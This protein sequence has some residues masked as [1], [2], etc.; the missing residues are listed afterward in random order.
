MFSIPLRIH[1]WGG[2][3]SQLFALALALD[4]HSRNPNR[5]LCIVFHSAG[6]TRRNLE[7]RNVPNFLQ[8][9]TVNDFRQTTKPPTTNRNSRS[10][11]LRLV[12]QFLKFTYFGLE[13]GNNSQ[14]N[15]IKPW[16]HSIRG[17]YSSRVISRYS[18][19]KIMEIIFGTKVTGDLELP[20]RNTA[21][22]HY[23]LG[24][25]LEL[26][27]KTYIAPN[28]VRDI[29]LKVQ[30]VNNVQQLDI[31]SDS[32]DKAL[33]FLAILQNIVELKVVAL[34]AAEVMWRLV[35]YQNFIGTNSKITIWVVLFRMNLK[36]EFMSF[37]P[38]ELK[39]YLE[40]NSAN[41]KYKSHLVYY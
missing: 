33:D 10:I 23:R 8:I 18:V 40:I 32:S 30:N 17:H 24:D 27:S 35:H 6:V 7:L 25:L 12:K 37:V 15:Q 41:S 19:E 2:C 36:S 14:L 31:Y 22:L 4:I 38:N 11:F 16:T 5:K 26:A 29:V 3:G 20:L 34:E 9:K 1:C 21:G 28:R 39:T 13:L